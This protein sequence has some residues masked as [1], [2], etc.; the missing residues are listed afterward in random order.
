MYKTTQPL[1]IPYANDTLHTVKR[2]LVQDT[3]TFIYYRYQNPK[4]ES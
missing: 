4:V 2:K 3:R 1:K